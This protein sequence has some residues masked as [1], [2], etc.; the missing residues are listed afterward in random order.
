MLLRLRQEDE[1]IAHKS[2]DVSLR[3]QKTIAA[4]SVSRPKSPPH[5]VTCS[6]LDRKVGHGTRCSSCLHNQCRWF[7]ATAR[8]SREFQAAGLSR[9]TGVHVGRIREAFARVNQAV[10]AACSSRSGRRRGSP[11]CEAEQEEEEEEAVSRDIDWHPLT[12]CALLP[13][14]K[15][16]VCSGGIVDRT[17]NRGTQ[18][19]ANSV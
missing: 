9:W 17:C 8:R 3:R 2:N 6:S 14:S 15:R 12:D 18:W 16:C 5:S 13:A 1:Q 10:H 19:H 11:V 4:I 7:G